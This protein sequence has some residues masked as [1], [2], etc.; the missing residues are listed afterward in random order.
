MKTLYITVHYTFLY[1]SITYNVQNSA[2]TFDGDYQESYIHK[3]TNLSNMVHCK[4]SESPSVL[5][6][7]MHVMI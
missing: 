3:Q 7:C 2:V 4:Q 6:W 1:F 5:Q